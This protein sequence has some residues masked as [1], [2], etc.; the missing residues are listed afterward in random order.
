[1]TYPVDEAG[2]VS[3][4]DGNVR[5]RELQGVTGSSRGQFPFKSRLCEGCVLGGDWECRIHSWGSHFLPLSMILASLG[6]A[7]SFSIR[8]YKVGVL[9]FCWW[10]TVPLQYKQ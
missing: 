3:T 4:E 7:H 1:M 5:S 9:P 2:D 8:L 10:V 6:S